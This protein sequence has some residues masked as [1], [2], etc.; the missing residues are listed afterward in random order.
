MAVAAAAEMSPA[1]A[2]IHINSDGTTTASL[3]VRTDELQHIC[4]ATE[5]QKTNTN[6]KYIEKNMPRQEACR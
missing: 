5:K 1:A 6:K 3:P 2:A 4:I